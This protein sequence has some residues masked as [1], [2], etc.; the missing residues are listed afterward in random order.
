[1][2]GGEASDACHFDI[3]FDIGPDMKP[4][5][6]VCDEGDNTDSSSGLPQL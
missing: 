2:T 5:A 3:L 1:M 4:R 6:V